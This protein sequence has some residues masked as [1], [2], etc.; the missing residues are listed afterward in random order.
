MI[1]GDRFNYKLKLGLVVAKGPSGSVDYPD[2]LEKTH[3]DWLTGGTVTNPVPALIISMEDVMNTALEVGGNPY[4]GE[5]SHD[6]STDLAVNQTVFDTFN[7][8]VGNISEQ[9]DF[10]SILAKAKTEVNNTILLS[11]AEIDAAVV[12]FENGQI[13][14]QYLRNI[15]LFQGGM[16]DINGVMSSAFAFGSA[17]IQSDYVNGVNRFKANLKLQQEQL[18]AQLITAYTESIKQMYLW[19]VNFKEDATKLQA[20]VNRIKTV[21]LK[22][23]ADRQ[24]QI[25]TNYALWDFNVF[26]YG[27][28]FLGA[29]AGAVPTIDKPSPLASAIG[30]ALSGAAT[31]AQVGSI[32]PGVGSAAGAGIGAVAGTLAAIL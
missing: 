12:E 2:F 32:I 4:S 31:G 16:V 24:L 8:D 17:M 15:T 23:K 6:P 7:T 19:R 1:T 26:Q 27:G 3:I 9:T 11:D 14:S 25:D 22:E 28:Q 18:R 29:I 30:G 5:L 10:A 21:A 13:L 20:E